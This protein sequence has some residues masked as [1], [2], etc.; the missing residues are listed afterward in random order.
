MSWRARSS[1]RSMSRSADSASVRSVAG[2]PTRAASSS[3]SCGS[4][5]RIRSRRA[6][7]SAS[8]RR[9]SL[10]GSG[11]TMLP[12]PSVSPGEGRRMTNRSPRPATAGC[13][14]TS[15]AQPSSPGS[16]RSVSSSR[17]LPTRCA[18]P[19]KTLTSRLCVI[20]VVASG[21]QC[22]RTS[23]SRLP[24]RVPGS[25]RTSPRWTAC[26]S[27]PLTFTATRLP[28]RARSSRLR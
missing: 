22:N 12:P 14:K 1:A 23:R 24:G 27:T 19:R 11:S 2:P 5:P 16:I 9:W 28:G 8:R 20:G 13:L 3:A 18:V 10:P 4:P 15:C 6:S 7:T 21:W 17:T 25:P 26:A